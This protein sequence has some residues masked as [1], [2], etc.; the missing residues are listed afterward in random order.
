MIEKSIDQL[1]RNLAH[2]MK[3]PILGRLCGVAQIVLGVAQIV[4]AVVLALISLVQVPWAEWKTSGQRLERS[5]SHLVN[6]AAN[7]FGG[8]LGSIPIVGLI[9][10]YIHPTNSSRIDPRYTSEYAQNVKTV[11]YDCLARLALVEN[12][13]TSNGSGRIGC[14]GRRQGALNEWWNG[15]DNE[16]DD[17]LCKIILD[18]WKERADRNHSVATEERLFSEETYQEL[19]KKAMPVSFLPESLRD[20]DLT[21]YPKLV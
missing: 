15:E 16:G 8:I 13:K 7:I 5:R 11:G 20:W 21:L 2:C 3:Y 1:E 17:N 9:Y 12:A 19:K 6:G 14:L 10:G 4:A 18:A